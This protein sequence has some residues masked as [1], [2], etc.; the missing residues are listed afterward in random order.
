MEEASNIYSIV[1][2]IVKGRDNIKR[3]YN[4][5]DRHTEHSL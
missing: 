5:K 4:K 2:G 3:N 1:L